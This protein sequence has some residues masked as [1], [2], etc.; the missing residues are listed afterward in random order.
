MNT[1]RRV[2]R[3]TKPSWKDEGEGDQPLPGSSISDAI[4]INGVKIDAGPAKPGAIA[5]EALCE[6]SL[7]ETTVADAKA[8][9][10][11][12]SSEQT[13]G[14]SQVLSYR[15]EAGMRLVLEFKAGLLN[16]LSFSA[17]GAVAAGCLAPDGGWYTPPDGGWY[18]R[19]GGRG[20]R[21]AGLDAGAD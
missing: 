8:L 21:G 19:A 17:A 12:P 3:S 7:G 2:G 10:G 20:R 16:N 11:E 18:P 5:S 13:A 1:S 4:T 15:Y 6:L 9:F 14:M